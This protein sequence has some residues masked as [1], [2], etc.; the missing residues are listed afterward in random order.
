MLDEMALHLSGQTTP[1][2]QI[3]EQFRRITLQVRDAR[4]RSAA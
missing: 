3:G 2:R 1:G 4:R